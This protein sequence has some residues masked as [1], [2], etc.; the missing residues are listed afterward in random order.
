[1]DHQSA[2][3]GRAYVPF[4][5]QAYRMLANLKFSPSGS[6][7]TGVPVVPPM[8]VAP[9]SSLQPSLAAALQEVNGAP[10]PWSQH[11]NS[12]DVCSDC[13]PAVFERLLPP[14]CVDLTT[15]NPTGG[16][17]SNDGCNPTPVVATTFAEEMNVI[18]ESQDLEIL[19]QVRTD[20][21]GMAA[22]VGGWAAQMPEDPMA[23]PV[24]EQLNSLVT[25]LVLTQSF[26][27]EAIE[28]RAALLPRFEKLKGLMRTFLEDVGLE[29]DD[30]ECALDLEEAH[31]TPP[32]RRRV[33]RKTSV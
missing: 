25:D 12:T 21:E 10:F 20:L 15:T 4:G 1:M 11:V 29:D 13:A 18:Y 27:F 31:R 9:P 22:V 3:D 30:C 19:G 32:K 16:G 26:A 2:S 14:G 28:M 33:T 7:I 5:G 8:G 6:P 24:V 17:S 23:A